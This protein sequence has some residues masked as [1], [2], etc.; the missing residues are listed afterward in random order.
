[1]TS[2]TNIESEAARFRRDHA[3]TLWDRIEV[4]ISDPRATH[5]TV[6]FDLPSP[7]RRGWQ[8]TSDRRSIPKSFTPFEARK[9]IAFA[10]SKDRNRI[11]TITG[12][13][14]EQD[15]TGARLTWAAALF[16]VDPKHETPVVL[17]ALALL[18]EDHLE[19]ARSV[20]AGAFLVETLAVVDA[21]L[22]LEHHEQRGAPLRRGTVGC[23]RRAVLLDDHGLLDGTFRFH[24]AATPAAY[25]A[26]GPVE[27]LE[28]HSRSMPPA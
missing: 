28:R 26:K 2:G 13:T 15:E 25:S 14:T 3:S 20:L 5:I 11:L 27:W 1:M 12:S 16:H 21:K 19:R 6:R 9:K 23:N 24:A 7:P 17:R 10:E 18:P 22:V 8:V 4:D